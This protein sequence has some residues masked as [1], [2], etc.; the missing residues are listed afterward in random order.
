MSAFF[1]I[2]FFLFG[3]I[4]FARP[5]PEFSLARHVVWAGASADGPL[6]FLRSP[7]IFPNFVKHLLPPVGRVATAATATAPTL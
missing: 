3:Q 2:T 5:L 6:L 4:S 1:L 7:D